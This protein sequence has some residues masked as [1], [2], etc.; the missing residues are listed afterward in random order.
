MMTICHIGDSPLG[1]Q[2]RTKKHKPG[3]FFKAQMI[4]RTTV[5]TIVHL[6]WF[7]I[8]DM[9]CIGTM[10]CV[11]LGVRPD[12]R[13]VLWNDLKDW[14]TKHNPTKPYTDFGYMG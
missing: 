7:H 11:D 8:L 3:T 1:A 2:W 10:H 6:P 5:N 13:K 4:A 14:Y 9:V 12:V